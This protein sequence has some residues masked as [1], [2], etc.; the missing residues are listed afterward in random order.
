MSSPTIPAS[1][2]S[3][4]TVLNASDIFGAG[5]YWPGVGG[6]VLL[7]VGCVGWNTTA[8]GTV[9]GTPFKMFKTGNFG[10]TFQDFSAQSPLY[11]GVTKKSVADSDIYDINLKACGLKLKVNTPYSSVAG[12][13]FCGTLPVGVNITTLNPSLIAAYGTSV[14]YSADSLLGRELTVYGSKASVVANNFIPPGSETDDYNAPFIMITNWT[15]DPTAVVGLAQN[16]SCDLEGVM[17]YDYRPSPSSTVTSLMNVSSMSPTDPDTYSKISQFCARANNFLSSTGAAPIIQGALPANTT[18]KTEGFGFGEMLRA[19]MDN[20]PPWVIPILGQA[21]NA[22]Y[23]AVV[24]GGAAGVAV[25]DYQHV[26][27]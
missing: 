27:L 5:T 25:A 10:G 19:G 21:G 4:G 24:G 1:I 9:A 16:Y 3:Q 20:V 11:S 6:A 14:S 8:T 12:R 13:I 18:V 7:I 26:Y 2:Q 23:Q 22:V 15:K 17:N